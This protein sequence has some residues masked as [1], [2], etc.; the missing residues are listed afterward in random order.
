MHEPQSLGLQINASHFL[1]QRTMQSEIV[2]RMQS[3]NPPIW[4]K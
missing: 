4:A 2:S 3:E 1:E